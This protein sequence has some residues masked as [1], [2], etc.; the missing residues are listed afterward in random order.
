MGD[1]AT[2]LLAQYGLVNIKAVKERGAYLCKAETGQKK[3]HKTYDNYSAIHARYALLEQL[4]ASGFP[5][6]D[7]ITLSLQD[8]PFV[9][10]GRETYIMSQYVPGREIDLNCLQ[11]MTLAM[12]SLARLHK[13]ARGVQGIPLVNADA[14]PVVFAK[15]A[16]FLAKTS[17]QIG[18]NTRLSDFDV[19]FVKNVKEYTART[20][21]A[22][23]LLAQTD[24]HFIFDNAVAGGHICHNALKEETLTIHN[25]I[26][27]ITGFNDAVVGAQIDDVANLMRRYVRRSN[28]EIPIGK[29]LEAYDHVLP[30]PKTADAIVRAALMHPWQFIKLVRQYYSKKRGWAP[31]AIMDRIIRLLE[32]QGKCDEYMDNSY[33]L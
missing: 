32:E 4:D 33:N 7:K 15:D 8:M 16:D 10:L 18:K 12:Q 20:E 21:K 29:L 30:L 19:I 24:Y 26:C 6:T 5:Y 1:F 28:R 25:D 13:A 11:D 3:I 2:T 14:F 22:A 23:E 17:R 27:H 31:A 9:Q